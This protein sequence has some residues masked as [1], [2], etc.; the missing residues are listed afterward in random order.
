LLV[1]SQAI[2]KSFYDEVTESFGRLKGIEK[3]ILC[4]NNGFFLLNIE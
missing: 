1:E 2:R 3:A 4:K